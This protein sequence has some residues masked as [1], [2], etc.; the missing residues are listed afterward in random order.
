VCKRGK[1]EI[2]YEKGR[3]GRRATVEQKMIVCRADFERPLPAP[4]RSTATVVT[5]GDAR[6]TGS[7]F[8]FGTRGRRKSLSTH[9]ET[10]WQAVR[11]ARRVLP[12]F[13]Q[14]YAGGGVA[15]LEDRGGAVQCYARRCV[16]RLFFFRV[17]GACAG[18]TSRRLREKYYVLCPC[19]SKTVRPNILHAPP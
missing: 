14:V 5:A 1:A 18:N 9:R 8:S 15:A 12:R 6:T 4:I 17:Q 11:A 10:Q 7:A 16:I 3:G 2:G 13:G 19:V